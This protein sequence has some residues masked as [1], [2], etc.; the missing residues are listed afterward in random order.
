[1]TA[2]VAMLKPADREPLAARVRELAELAELM[3]QPGTLAEAPRAGPAAPRG[4]RDRHREDQAVMLTKTAER[5]VNSRIRTL[6][7]ERQNWLAG[8]YTHWGE[9]WC[10]GPGSPYHRDPCCEGCGAG[11][12]PRTVRAYWAGFVPAASRH[13]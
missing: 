8:K 10:A 5:A 11:A 2:P 12:F 9:P 6:R 13:A 4:P 1:M 7:T 3:R